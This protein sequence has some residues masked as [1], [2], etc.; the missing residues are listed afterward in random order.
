MATMRRVL[1][2]TC[3]LTLLAVIYLSASVLIL[4]PPR[5]NVSVWF[6]LA[7]VFI[8]VGVLTLTALSV[9][10]RSASLR[11]PVLASGSLLAAIGVWLVRE[12][13]TRAHFEGY[14]LVLGSMLVVQGALT[15][16]AFVRPPA[17][18]L[19]TVTP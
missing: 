10:S 13:L 3:A 2:V 9:G 8:A 16:A 7:A 19:T 6:T 5:T 12:T 14:A 11:Y 18:R 1:A 4:R 17:E 15:V